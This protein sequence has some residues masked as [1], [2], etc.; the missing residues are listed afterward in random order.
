[1]T[2]SYIIFLVI[3]QKK[4]VFLSSKTKTNLNF[5]TR[6]VS[7]MHFLNLKIFVRWRHR[8][9]HDVTI[10]H[11][12]YAVFQ[13][14]LIFSKKVRKKLDLANVLKIFCVF[15]VSHAIQDDLTY[16][17]CYPQIS[18]SLTNLRVGW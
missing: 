8:F 6:E 14:T 9:D 5:Y 16:R 1:M 12:L 2:S 18:I 17:Y 13:N 3:L 10:K 15:D 7:S 11:N 4:L